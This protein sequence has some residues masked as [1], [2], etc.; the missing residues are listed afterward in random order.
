MRQL[1]LWSLLL[2]PLCVQAQR[3]TEY[4]QK[5]DE[6]MRRKDY[7]DA[8]LWYEEGVSYC[9]P[10]SINQLTAIWVT[11]ES[12]HLSLGPVM[13]KCLDCLNS[14]AISK[15]DTL[16]MKKLILFYSDGIGTS[17]DENSANSWR[18]ML[19]QLRNPY[20]ELYRPKKQQKKTFFFAGLSSLPPVAPY[21]IQLGGGG[22]V[23]WYVRARS[24]LVFPRKTN[25][26]ECVNGEKNGTD[27]SGKIPAFDETGQLYR[28][29][30]SGDETFAEG[31]KSMLIGTAGLMFKIVPN[32]YLSA[33]AG[34]VKYDVSYEYEKIDKNSALPVENGRGW[35][36]NKDISYQ[37]VAVDV[38]AMVVMGKWFYATAG[39]SVLDLKYIY[40][41]VG[42]GIFFNIK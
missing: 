18:E 9:D 26:V 24:N 35:A 22:S 3:Q 40:P 4:N 5:G 10:Y 31:E 25:G 14:M 16:A 15:K 34:Y 36:R 2:F 33:G 28:F 41:N 39:C 6:A 21:G 20:P 23:G 19:M 29:I 11:D 7:R 30:P 13:N 42:V 1:I 37:S 27:Y 8:K 12:M 38:D 17:K 32:V